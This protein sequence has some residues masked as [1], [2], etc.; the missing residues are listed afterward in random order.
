MGDAVWLTCGICLRSLYELATF[1]H[2]IAYAQP[3]FDYNCDEYRL[4]QPSD[5]FQNTTKLKQTGYTG[6]CL[7]TEQ[8]F[9]Q[10]SLFTSV[11][12]MCIYRCCLWAATTARRVEFCGGIWG[13]A[14]S[15]WHC[16][17]AEIVTFDATV[18]TC[19]RRFGN[20]RAA[21]SGCMHAKH[22]VLVASSANAVQVLNS[23]TCSCVPCRCI[24]RSL[25]RWRML[26]SSQSKWH[27]MTLPLYTYI[28]WAYA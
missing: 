5:W 24:V 23:L 15:A 6:M 10:E 19:H 17:I 3:G 4:K 18:P 21:A 12:H 26:V 22:C 9:T 11:G 16:L 7:D 20:K 14:S 25:S 2:W 1:T 8:V 28:Q 13:A 27:A